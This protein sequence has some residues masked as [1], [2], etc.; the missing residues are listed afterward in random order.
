MDDKP[1]SP[2][3]CLGCGKPMTGRPIP[4]EMREVTGWITVRS[5]G[6]ANS[7]V[8]QQPTGRYLCT[9]C[10]ALKRAGVWFEQTTMFD[11]EGL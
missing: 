1:D 4:G 7:V 10:G 6:G 9:Q 8:Q 3:N 2:L 5:R 11:A